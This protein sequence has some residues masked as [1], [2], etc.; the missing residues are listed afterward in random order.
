M[1]VSYVYLPVRFPFYSHFQSNRA[2]GMPMREMEY[3]C[4]MVVCV[5][6][7]VQDRIFDQIH[8]VYSQSDVLMHVPEHAYLP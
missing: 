6:V 2:D 5:C 7:Y 1:S 4:A 3:V 8:L